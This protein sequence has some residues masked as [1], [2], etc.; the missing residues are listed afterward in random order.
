M[1]QA[2][3]GET[4]DH[5]SRRAAQEIHLK[6]TGSCN[7]IIPGL[8][9]GSNV[10]FMDG[11]TRR[12]LVE[13]RGL[14]RVI[15]IIPPDFKM[16]R[17]EE[18]VAISQN[19]SIALTVLDVEDDECSSIEKIFPTALPLIQDVL[20]TR[21][22]AEL[23][24][25]EERPTSCVLV[26]C[27]AGVSRSASVVIAFL[28]ACQGWSLDDAMSFVKG[29]RKCISPNVAFAEQLASFESETLQ[30]KSE[31]NVR[32]YD[33]M[34]MRFPHF[35]NKQMREFLTLPECD[36][37]EQKLHDYMQTESV[38]LQKEKVIPVKKPFLRRGGGKQAVSAPTPAKAQ[39]E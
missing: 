12:A 27:M 36:G 19:E 28:I 39:N 25:G 33:R 15:R 16:G 1:A 14:Q 7:E 23:A 26:H 32:L 21:P 30:R 8:W 31:F 4:E 37:D 2:S 29:K 38:R 18:A 35:T 20:G 13:A 11:T 5:V 22:K 34:Q 3:A 24:D 6:E 10:A 9:L 17:H